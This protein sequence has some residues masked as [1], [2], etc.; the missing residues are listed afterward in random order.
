MKLSAIVAAIQLIE[1]AFIVTETNARDIRYFKAFR[2]KISNEVARHLKAGMSGKFAKGWKINNMQFKGNVEWLPATQSRRYWV[3]SMGTLVI[4]VT[5]LETR[6]SQPF[7]MGT[8]QVLFGEGKFGYICKGFTFGE[9][10]YALM[11]QSKTEWEFKNSKDL[12]DHMS[13]A[14]IHSLND[15]I[16]Y[17]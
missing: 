7:D 8:M 6:K 3:L 14:I 11:Y 2:D 1:A 10:R 13:W 17:L 9:D 12:T 16:N 5:N 15:I 4:D